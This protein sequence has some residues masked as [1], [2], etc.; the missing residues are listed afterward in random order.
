MKEDHPGAIT[1]LKRSMAAC[2]DR[3]EP[4]ISLAIVYIMMGD[5]KKAEKLLTLVL[6]KEPANRKAL[7]LLAEIQITRKD[8]AAAMQTLERI[9]QANPNDIEAQY[10]K[11]L[12][13]I[14]MQEY[15]NARALADAMVQAIP[16]RPE[17]TVSRVRPF[18]KQ[19]YADAIP[20]FRSLVRNRMPEPI[21]FSALPLLSE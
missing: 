17:A 12:L 14:D 21:I 1:L 7:F 18:F 5:A 9:V 2:G 20:R 16:K 13:Y 6:A 10:R 8:G 15:D 19:Q 11:G 4:K 3:S